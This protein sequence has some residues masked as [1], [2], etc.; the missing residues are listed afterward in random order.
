MA[1]RAGLLP[2]VWATMG[3]GWQGRSS[4]AQ[5]GGYMEYLTGIAIPA[6]TQGIQ[7]GRI[8]IGTPEKSDDLSR[9]AGFVSIYMVRSPSCIRRLSPTSRMRAVFGIMSLWNG[10]SACSTTR[11]SIWANSPSALRS[12]VSSVVWIGFYNTSPSQTRRC[13]QPC[14][15]RLRHY[16]E[17]SR[18]GRSRPRAYGGSILRARWPR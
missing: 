17:G 18:E 14:P 7:A 12:G 1:Q 5:I 3:V 4:I 16:S 6:G 10:C 2:K 9:F 8:G 13:G 15:H 11:P